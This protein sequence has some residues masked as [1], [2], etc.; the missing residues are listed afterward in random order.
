MPESADLRENILASQ[1]VLPK[2]LIKIATSQRIRLRHRS[3]QLDHL[4]KMIVRLA[5]GLILGLPRVKQEVAGYQ[6]K[7]HARKR[8]EVRADIIVDAEHD[9]RPPILPGLDL[10]REVVM[11]PTTIPQIANFQLDVLCGQW[12]SPMHVLFKLLVLRLGQT[13]P[14]LSQFEVS[15]NL[16]G[17][18]SL[19]NQLPPLLF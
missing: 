16:C 9:L 17:E 7:N 18:I 1:R 15:L 3:K 4:G 5:V 19:K 13:D 2:K 14:L 11:G 10:V 8:P 6:L 12:P